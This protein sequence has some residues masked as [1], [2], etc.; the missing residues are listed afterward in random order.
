MQY[1]GNLAIKAS[2]GS[3]VWQT[4][5]GG[6]SG[7]TFRLQNDGYLVLAAYNH[8]R[9][10]LLDSDGYNARKL[11][12]VENNTATSGTRRLSSREDRHLKTTIQDDQDR[13]LYYANYNHAT[14]T[15]LYYGVSFVK[16][17]RMPRVASTTTTTNSCGADYSSVKR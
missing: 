16:V 2:D 13:R 9:L 1:N 6:N 12:K 4:G 8:G 10:W 5:T 17:W 7:A 15:G 11:S 14:A 3:I